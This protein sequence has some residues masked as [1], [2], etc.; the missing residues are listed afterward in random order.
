ME[1]MGIGVRI[2]CGRKVYGGQ[3]YVR[4][5][6]TGISLAGFLESAHEQAGRDQQRQRQADLRNHETAQEK[7]I[8]DS[9][10]DAAGFFLEDLGRGDSGRSPCRQGA[11][12]NA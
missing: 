12:D 6:E 3:Q 8:M 11:A 7:L 10:R 1:Y 5:V 4:S 2:A 9:G